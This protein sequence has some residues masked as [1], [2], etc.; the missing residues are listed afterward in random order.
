MTNLE[1]LKSLTEYRSQNDNLFEKSLLDAGIATGGTYTA[2]AEQSID[3]VMADIY[4]SLSGHPELSDGRTG[5]KYPVEKLL[6][7]RKRLYD[8]WGLVLPEISSQANVPEVTG[9]VSVART[10]FW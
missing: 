4:L 6:E 2:S 3:L 10:N 7:L 1:A 9:K 8:K 5:I